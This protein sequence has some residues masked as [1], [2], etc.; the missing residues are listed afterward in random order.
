MME[1]NERII[2]ERN[3]LAQKVVELEARNNSVKSSPEKEKAD[4]QQMFYPKAGEL[5]PVR[6]SPEKSTPQ[7]HSPSLNPFAL[8]LSQASPAPAKPESKS[9]PELLAMFSKM[10]L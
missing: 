6:E 10:N 9:I 4:L 8:D 3:H 7:K 1:Q 5:T 2:K